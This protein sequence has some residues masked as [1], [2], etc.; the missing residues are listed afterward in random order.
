MRKS[1]SRQAFFGVKYDISDT[2]N[3]FADV[4]VGHVESN[5]VQSVS[6][7]TMSGPWAFSVFRENAYLPASVRQTMVTENRP[8]FLI[9]K[10]GSF[11]GEL[12]IYN[13]ERIA[14][15]VRLRVAALR[16]RLDG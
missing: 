10:A 8:S 13:H 1:F 16:R 12:D 2:L 5:G 14:Q 7:A 11:P 3:V 6:A 9:H 15:R 4:L